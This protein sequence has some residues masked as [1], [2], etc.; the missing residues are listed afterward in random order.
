MFMMIFCHKWHFATTF[1]LSNLKQV[2]NVNLSQAK[3]CQQWHHQILDEIC[4]KQIWRIFYQII[5][6]QFMCHKYVIII[7]IILVTYQKLPHGNLWNR[8]VGK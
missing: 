2:A 8:L 6:I 5:W 7:T 3:W 4:D 1:A